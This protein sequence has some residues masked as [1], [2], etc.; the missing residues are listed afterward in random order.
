MPLN[1]INV[2]AAANDNTGDSLRNAFIKINSNNTYLDGKA[3]NAHT[4]PLSELT[5][6]GATGGQVPTWNGTAWVPATPAGSGTVT[7]VGL[8]L[9]NVFTVSNSPV[10][11]AGTITATFASQSAGTVL[12][13]P[14]GSSAAPSFRALVATDIPPLSYEA[15]G[16][17]SAHAALTSGAHGMSTYGSEFVALTTAAAAR[18]KLSLGTSSTLN[19]PATGNA[20][21]TEVVLGT[22]TRLTNSRTPTAHVHAA[23]DITSGTLDI[24]RIPTGTSAATVCIGND[25]RLSDS[26]T[27]LAHTHSASDVTSGTFA[28][29]L[30]PTGTTASTVCIG[31][32]ARLSDARTPVSHT[33]GNITN[34]GAIGST[35]N[36]PLITTTSG[37]IT[38]GAFGSTANTF[39]QGNDA[40]LSDSRTPTAH[41]HA[42]SDLTQSGATN[43]QVP[44]W[45]GT[46]WAPANVAASQ[47]TFS[48]I[49]IAGQSSVVADSTS[50]TLTLVAG[51]NVTLTTDATTDTIT[52]SASGGSGGGG[53]V[54]GPNSGITDNAIVRWDLVNTQIQNSVI[55]LSDVGEVAG[56]NSV[57]FSTSP[58]G[59]SAIGKMIWNSTNKTLSIG[60]GDG[61]VSALLGVDSHVLVRNTTGIQINKGQVVRVNG[62]STGN[63]TVALAQGNNDAN[64]TTTIGVAAENIANSGTGMVIVT[65]LLGGLDTSAWTAG[66]MLFV[67]ATTAGLLVNAAP[68]APNH[69]VRMGYVVSSNPNSGIIYVNVDNGYELDELHD[70]AYPTAVANNDFLVYTTNRWE[71]KTPANARTALG[72]GTLATLSTVPYSS[73]DNIATSRLLGRTTAGTGAAETLTISNAL[74]LVTTTQGAIAYRAAAQWFGLAPSTSG[75]VLTTNGAAANPSWGQV[76]LASAVT[77][78]LPVGN[79]GTGATTLTGYVK[80]AGTTALTASSTIPASDITG[81]AAVATSGSASDLGA[82]T[83]PAA[84]LPALTGDVTTTAGTAATTIAANAVTT[85]KIANSNV[86]LAKIENTTGLSVLGNAGTVAAAPANITGTAGQV[87]RV[88]NGGTALAFGA[89]DLS[90]A[91]AIT[92]TLAVTNGGTGLN[93]IGAANR[94]ILSNGTITYW[95]QIDLAAAV[96]G[97]LPVGNGGTGA[98]TLTGYVKGSGTTALTASSTIPVADVSGLGTGVATFLATPT[99]AN[100]A[101]AVTDETGTGSLVFATSPTLVTPTLGVA[102]ATSINK[103]AI[104]APLTGSTLTIADGKTLTASNTLTFTGTDLSSV[105]FG[106]GGTVAYT[107]GNLSQ[108][109]AT[110]SAQLAGVISDE[111]GSG[112]LVFATSPALAGT[113]TSTTAVADTNTTQ[114]A[115]TAYVVGQASS[116]T[117][118]ALGTAAVGTSLK[119]ARADHVHALPTISLTTGVSGQLPIANGGTGQATQT[120]GFNALS[121][122]TTKGDLILHDGTNSVR[123]AVGVTNGHVLTVDSTAATGVKWAAASGGG[124]TSITN[125]WIPAAQWIPRTTT[126]CGVDSREQATNKINTDEL[127]FDPSTNWFAQCIV[128]MPSN[129]NAGTVTA[130][131]HWTAASGTGNIIWGL[132]GRAYAD[133]N[134]LDQ[135]MGTAQTVTDTLITANAEH[136]TSATAAITLGGTA[137]AGNAV[138]FELYRDA[139]AVGDTL[140]TDGRLLGV[141]IGYTSA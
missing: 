126:G 109:A 101:A 68:A 75:Y 10:T 50:D 139:A 44:S 11:G 65:G 117:P 92:G 46:A 132:S 42:L 128:V 86:T 14:A 137:A 51:T 60:I 127:R 23:A 33:H 40:R 131:F 119:Y 133:G 55:T 111:T 116:T 58:S 2:G 47:N 19:V 53:N 37:V 54:S 93:V 66:D 39:C 61:S 32:D 30:I 18:T 98:T 27:P 141:E 79:G 108:F 100:L 48:T 72:L 17:V 110:T 59:S 83:L 107:G 1:P 114:I 16:A 96:Q 67:S 135:A 49:A 123:L 13:A 129:W 7:S 94:A 63:M 43:G 31:N 35:A 134:A 125:V 22:D 85:A 115:T 104:T 38:V 64:T 84:R 6:S 124:G 89:V 26:R 74:D 113:P 140:A 77:G 118:A 87:L 52:I 34:V 105:A 95:G 76:N 73:V 69:A 97:T 102:S 12:A 70:V 4:H 9:P 121:P 56:A 21:N 99:A 106:A 28:I 8:S 45:N 3:P 15:S 20:S 5:Q 29:G 130:K 25:V 120:A 112:A 78:T 62:A 138:I 24:G 136:I 88:N 91:G 80:G 90:A 81:L 103:V 41:T 82:G 36:L 122:A 71:N 57:A